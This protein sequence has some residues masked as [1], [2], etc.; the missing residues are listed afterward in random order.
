[1]SPHAPFTVERTG[2]TPAAVLSSLAEHELAIIVTQADFMAAASRA[3][4]SVTAEDLELYDRVREKF[5]QAGTGSAA[6]TAPAPPQ[7]QQRRGAK[8]Q[9]HGG[10]KAAAY[11]AAAARASAAERSVA[12]P[13]VVTDGP[14]A[15]A[16]SARENAAADSEPREVHIPDT[17]AGV[18]DGTETTDAAAATAAPATADTATAAPPPVSEPAS[19]QP[20]AAAGAL[21]TDNASAVDSAHTLNRST[22]TA[23]SGADEQRDGH[24]HGQQAPSQD[25]H[26]GEKQRRRRHRKPAS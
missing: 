7:P 11:K 23:A 26:G 13:V 16:I 19:V 9:H 5:T 22:S 17:A 15:G 6:V 25:G 8:E 2:N 12:A 3:R 14:R 18:A 4:P 1:M 24:A 20:H 21:D 10:A